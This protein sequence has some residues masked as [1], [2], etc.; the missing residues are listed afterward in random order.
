MPW[1]RS[2]VT[3]RGCGT[4]IS[5]SRCTTTMRSGLS[6]S[7]LW[8]VSCGRTARSCLVRAFRISRRPRSGATAGAGATSSAVRSRSTR[9]RAERFYGLGQ[10]QHGLLDQKGA[11]IDLVQRNTEVSV[12]FALSSRGYGFLWNMPGVGR[13]ELGRQP[14]AV[15][16]G[17]GPADRLLGDGGPHAGRDRQPLCAGDG[18]APD[19]AGVGVGFLAVQVALPGPRRS[20]SRSRAS[21]SAAVFRCR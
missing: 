9:T 2:R 7:R 16:R 18:V 1:W 20:C 13:V 19:A 17:G 11:V 6:V 4:V 21:T 14:H 12:P 10:H 8:C 5:L 3:G 15:G